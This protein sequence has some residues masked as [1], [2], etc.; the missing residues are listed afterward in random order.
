[1]GIN[2]YNN[3]KKSSI[4]LS[5]GY[6]MFIK[7]R[8]RVANAWDKEFGRHY[9]T[10]KYCYH[11]EDYKRFN[12]KGNEILMNERFK[13]EDNDILDFL[14]ASDCEGK[15]SYKTCKKVYELIKDII[16]PDLVLRYEY[17]SNNDWEDFKQLLQD[18]YKYRTCMYWS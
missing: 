16:E 6:G 12:E 8:E 18:C 13:D 2:I 14:F 9:S 4:E 1:M 17:Y 3:S 7:I 5:G 15:I 10:L 11:K